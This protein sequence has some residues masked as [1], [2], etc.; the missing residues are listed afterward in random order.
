M[1]K[2]RGLIIARY[3]LLYWFMMYFQP[4]HAGKCEDLKNE[5][6]TYFE[7]LQTLIIQESPKEAYLLADS[8]LQ[9]IS[10]RKANDCEISLWIRFHK[11]EAI[12]LSLKFED[13]LSQY[14]TIIND[15][16]KNQKWALVAQTHL[17]I[18]RSHE[19][20]KR[21]KDCLR[22]LKL[23][24]EIIKKYHLMAEESVFAVRYAS[25]H[26][27][28]DN[29]DSAR[30]YAKIAVDLGE[31]AGVPR[32]QYDGYLL[33]ASLEQD[34]QSSIKYYKISAELFAKN[35]NYLG[36]SYMYLN[37]AK[38][39]L[40]LNEYEN[41]ME[42]VDSAQKNAQLIYYRKEEFN[43]IMYTISEL[44]KNYFEKYKMPDS[45]NFYQILQ[46]DYNAKSQW[47]IDQQ[48]IETNAVEFAIEREKNKLE[49]ARQKSN[50]LKLGLGAMSI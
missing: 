41:M 22:H 8:L 9:V 5:L 48:K 31:K 23:A 2:S 13:A 16:E 15:A 4:L 10:D 50:Y 21:P 33:M 42:Y 30:V 19:F 44:K 27:I 6:Q 38:R 45:V 7:Q 35:K 20:I 36:A 47:Y 29:K 14:Y 32:S 1:Y 43:T 25:Y 18:A 24:L 3:W 37:I 34:I 26:R 17:A 49:N 40:Q 12:E 46:R 28:F 11:A 39:T